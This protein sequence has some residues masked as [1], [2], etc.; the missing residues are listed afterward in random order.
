MGNILNYYS[1]NIYNGKPH[2]HGKL[3]YDK[4]FKK[5]KYDGEWDNGKRH[6]YGKS[7]YEN[8]NLEFDGGWKDYKWNGHGKLFIINGKLMYDG[9]W[10]NGEEEGMGKSYYENGNLMYDGKWENGI[11]VNGNWLNGELSNN[12]KNINNCC[13]CFE[14]IDIRYV[15]IPCGHS[16]ICYNCINK[17][18]CICPICK[19][20]FDNHIRVFL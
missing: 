1:G 11:I 4:E 13:I 17:L 18:D 5:I 16:Q 2:G 8:G 6:G 14:D 19:K 9:E 20:Y 7:Y 10:K 15:L 3:Y 12:S